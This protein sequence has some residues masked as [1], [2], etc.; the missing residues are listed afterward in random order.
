MSTSIHDDFSRTPVSSGNL[1]PWW[2]LLVIEIGVMISIPIFVFGG[3]LGL[4]LSFQDLVLSTFSGAAILGVIGALTARLGAVLRCTTALIARITF[5]SK[6]AS[7]IAFVLTM[8]MTGWWGVQT[9]MFA[10]AVLHLAQQVFNVNLNREVL[11]AVGGVAMI[12]TAALGIRAIGRLSYLAVPL[13]TG[14]LVYALTSLAAPAQLSDLLQYRPALGTTLGFGAAAAMVTGGFV[15]GASMNPDYS[16]FARTT[17]HAL[18]YS[19]IDY[20]L[21]YPALLVACGAIAIHFRSNDIMIHLVPPGLTWLIF[22]M[23]MFATW[24]ANDCNLYSSSLSLAAIL[25]K[26]Q[27]SHLAIAAGIVGIVLAE[28]HVVDHMVSFLTLL[29]ILIAPISGI[30][31]INA[32]CRKEP[33]QEVELEQVPNWRIPPLLAWI[34]GAAVGFVATPRESLG[35]GLVQ[36]TTVPTLDSIIAASIVMVMFLIVGRSK[37]AAI[38]VVLCLL[39]LSG[40]L[41]QAALAQ[42]KSQAKSQAPVQTKALVRAFSTFW[43]PVVG[44]TYPEIELCDLTGKKVKLSSYAGRVILLEPIGMSCPACQAFVGGEKKGGINGVTPQ[45]GT[46]SLESYLAAAGVSPADTRVVHVQLLLY[47]PNMGVPT[48]AEAQAWAKHFDF[49]RRSNEV[50][51][52]GDQRYINQHSYD[53]IPGMQLIDKNFVLVCDA[54]GH[55]P[56]SSL[57]SELIPSV[58]KLLH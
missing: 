37:K 8:G 42:A 5:G 17:K 53:M 57:F 36:L 14:G 21:V 25:P 4:G 27:R 30:F 7:C 3:Q 47:G 24:A 19:I 52:V 33:V 40:L 51:L 49:G 44:R 55:N 56:R 12:T 41:S 11:I 31:V 45:G 15:V 26:W 28:L 18:A 48:L 50:L 46:S 32:C 16:R 13:L 23:M 35:L 20:A 2:Y 10:N 6:G 34:C 43:P 38:V 39:S 1:R 29:G 54:T 22:V 58:S 9:E